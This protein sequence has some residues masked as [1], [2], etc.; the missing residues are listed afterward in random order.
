MASRPS[1]HLSIQCSLSY[2][3]GC[4]EGTCDLRSQCRTFIRQRQFVGRGVECAI[5]KAALTTAGSPFAVL[6]L[7]GPER[8]SRLMGKLRRRNRS[9]RWCATEIDARTT[10]MFAFNQGNRLP[11]MSERTGKWNSRLACTDDQNLKVGHAGLFL[12]G[13]LKGA[14]EHT[15]SEHFVLE[16]FVV[17][18]FV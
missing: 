12:F 7:H 1:L 15:V 5:F 10:K 6:Y 8:T 14:S 17:E 16:Y 3:G 18:H 9:L 11:D 4:Q 2:A 13:S